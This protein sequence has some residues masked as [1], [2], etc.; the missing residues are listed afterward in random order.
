MKV[1]EIEKN[2]R[3]FIIENPYGDK[4]KL[5]TSSKGV[6]ITN[7]SD[8]P[9]STEGLT[10]EKAYYGFLMEYQQIRSRKKGVTSEIYVKRT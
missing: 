1:T 4:W 2:Q 10:H 9:A 5:V 7:E 8:E 6:I 3:T